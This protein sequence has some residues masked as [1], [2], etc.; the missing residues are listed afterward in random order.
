M[1]IGENASGQC[2]LAPCQTQKNR[3]FLLPEPSFRRAEP[4]RNHAHPVPPQASPGF[5]L[6]EKNP[7]SPIHSFE[8]ERRALPAP[9][10]LK[11]V[12]LI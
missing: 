3:V 11:C 10:L 1:G 4:T 7:C 2:G 9:L 12:L 8:D 6:F 5:L